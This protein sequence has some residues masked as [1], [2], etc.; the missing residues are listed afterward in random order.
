[1]DLGYEIFGKREVN[2]FFYALNLIHLACAKLLEPF[3]HR[4]D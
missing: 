1:M 4:L 3:D 2:S